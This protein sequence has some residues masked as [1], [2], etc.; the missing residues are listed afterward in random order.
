MFL[1]EVERIAR[2]SKNL[3]KE[4]NVKVL[5]QFDA[6][7]LSSASILLRALVREDV[8]FEM[9]ILKQLTED[10]IEKIHI[11]EN[12]V[13]ILSDFGSG[14]L[15]ML[16]DILD[17]TQVIVLDHHEPKDL[18]HENLFHINPLLFGEKEMSAS[19]VCYFFAKYLNM[20]N[21]D[22]ADLAIIGATGDAADEKWE[23]KGLIKKVLDE[24]VLIGKISVVRGT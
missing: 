13:L 12:D 19:I 24:G 7:G 5:S 10:E 15:H 1:E 18:K 22:L 6:D 9:R 3:I 21:V 11:T 4:K 23:F 8:N 14:Q 2:V 20:K 17:K 16:K